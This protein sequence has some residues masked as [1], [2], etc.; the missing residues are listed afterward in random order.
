MKIIKHLCITLLV[1]VVGLLL[2]I[3]SAKIQMG[4]DA[5]EDPI[6]GI[7]KQWGCPISYMTTAP[8]YTWADYHLNRFIANSVFWCA[9]VGG[10][11]IAVRIIRKRK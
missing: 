7:R 6:V 4:A 1:L 3:I 8:G 9:A 2:S 5:K 11:W 10:V